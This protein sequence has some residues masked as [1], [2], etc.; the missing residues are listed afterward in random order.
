MTDFKCERCGA[1]VP[2]SI[3]LF[4]KEKNEHYHIAMYY[5]DNDEPFVNCGPVTEKQKKLTVFKDL[6]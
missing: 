1:T 6:Q 4:N 2:K 3:L 5:R